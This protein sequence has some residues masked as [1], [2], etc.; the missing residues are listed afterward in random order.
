M[1][2]HLR[3]SAKSSRYPK[4]YYHIMIDMLRP[5][6]AYA[7]ANDI[8]L[9][10]I[11]LH[12]DFGPYN[13]IFEKFVTRVSCDIPCTT[14]CMDSYDNFM[15]LIGLMRP[16]AASPKDKIVFVRRDPAGRRCIVNEAECIAALQTR[17]EVVPVFFEGLTIDEQAN[18]VAG[19]KA[20]IGAHGAGFTNTLF[21][22]P[23][24]Y[25]IELMPQSFRSS[26]FRIL[27]EYG[28]IY[29]YRIH[30][31]DII[32]P[33]IHLDDFGEKWWHQPY[34][35]QLRDVQY[36]MDPVLLVNK[37]G[38][39]LNKMSHHVTLS[40]HST[41]FKN[42]YYHI[43]VDMLRPIAAYAAANDISLNEIVLHGEFGPFNHVFEHFVKRVDSTRDVSSVTVCS[44]EYFRYEPFVN[45]LKGFVKPAKDHLIF[46][47]RDPAGRRCIV[48]EAE[49]IAALQ[50][51][52]EVVPVFF[53]GLTM[54]EQAQVMAG[55]KIL[56][57]AHGAGFTN[58]LFM[59][60][61]TYVM[62]IFPES[63]QLNYFSEICRAKNIHHGFIHGVGVNPPPI[64]LEEF[65]GVWKDD[66]AIR[67][68]RDVRFTVDPALLITSIDAL[69]NA[70]A[71]HK[72]TRSIRYFYQNL[73]EG[74]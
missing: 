73:T 46:V 39:I 49:C 59:A 17:Y 53:E 37:I 72:K 12:G 13:Y 69:L 16:V 26:L 58:I 61:E 33:P 62:E 47:R 11:V 51:R 57:G 42:N 63:F 22:Q 8:S 34:S 24:T 32:P 64:T 3:L 1:P 5:I 41:R 70:E 48:N 10:E 27:S 67:Q 9:N 29:Y 35:G 66:P 28:Q 31:I 18:I 50:T 19:C 40:M 43:M 60:P 74:S 7:A 2:H 44:R 52:Y 25:L 23:G 55:C 21:M 68:L 14:I 15:P 30:G 71:V 6:A 54:E 38:N 4:N 56:T 20:M 36:T 65:T 45:L